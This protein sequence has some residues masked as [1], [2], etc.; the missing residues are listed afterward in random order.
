[1]REET[2]KQKSY[3][4]GGSSQLANYLK[5]INKIGDTSFKKK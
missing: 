1:M 5:E 3:T 2:Q 4:K